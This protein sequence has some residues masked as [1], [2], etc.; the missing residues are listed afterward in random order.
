M[1]KIFL[2]LWLFLIFYSSSTSAIQITHPHTWLN[3]TI[4]S[5]QVS[6]LD[7]LDTDSQFYL[8]YLENHDNYFELG[9]EFYSRKIA[10][11]FAYAF[12]SLLVFWNL[13]RFKLFFRF[14]LSW[15]FA[16]IIACIDEFNQ[17]LMVGRSGRLLDVVLDSSSA[18]IILF[19]VF[20]FF[21]L[22]RVNRPARLQSVANE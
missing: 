6:L 5:D 15:L 2:L 20:V 3:D 4:Y 21:V 11:I 22:K 17:Y 18:F 1:K 14:S 7:I 16:A 12:L 19:G 13:A 10:H 9:T 8:G